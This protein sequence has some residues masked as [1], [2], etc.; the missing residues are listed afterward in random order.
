MCILYIDP[1]YAWQRPAKKKKMMVFP[2]EYWMSDK[3][4]GIDTNF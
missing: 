3:Q 4:T 1:C 2:V